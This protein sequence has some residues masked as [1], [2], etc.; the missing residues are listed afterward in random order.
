MGSNQNETR[1]AIVRI[2]SFDGDDTFL[3]C[4]NGI[5]D[6]LFAVVAFDADGTAEIVD[7]GYRSYAEA[8]TAWPEASKSLSPK[9]A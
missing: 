7:Q 3:K 8:L 5:Q 4:G 1:L 6:H 9:S 2:E